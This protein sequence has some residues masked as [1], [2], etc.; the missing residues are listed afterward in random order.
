MTRKARKARKQY[1]LV[2]DDLIQEVAARKAI[3]ISNQT[4]SDELDLSRYHVQKITNDPRY[5]A[6]FYKAIET[7][8]AVISGK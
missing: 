4:I 5:S 1:K 6:V 2:T 8:A 7:I 3:G